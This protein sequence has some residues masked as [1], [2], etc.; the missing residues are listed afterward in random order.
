MGTVPKE[1]VP[2]QKKVKHFVEKYDF[3]P[4]RSWTDYDLQPFHQKFLETF[5]VAITELSAA[6]TTRASARGQERPEGAGWFMVAW[7][8]IRQSSALGR[9]G[10]NHVILCKE[11]LFYSDQ[12]ENHQGWPIGDAMTEFRLDETAPTGVWMTPEETMEW[13]NGCNE[14]ELVRESG[15]A[16][17]AEGENEEDF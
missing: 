8:E 1:Y 17:V 11:Q 16:S 5:P 10:I 14:E 15:L 12:R 6:E 4:P 9:A 3:R 2:F 13:H 7:I